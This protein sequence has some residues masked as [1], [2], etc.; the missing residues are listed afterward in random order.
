MALWCEAGDCA[1]IYGVS[2]TPLANIWNGNVEIA[3]GK[4]LNFQGGSYPDDY[5]TVGGV[6][7]GDGAVRIADGAIFQ[8]KS[9]NTYTGGTNRPSLLPLESA[10]RT[11]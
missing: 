5:L 7:S 10:D 2:G 11:S 6:I 1:G 3:A 9:A 4:T 8:F